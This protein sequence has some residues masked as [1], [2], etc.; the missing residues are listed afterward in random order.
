MV[1]E[2]KGLMEKLWQVTFTIL[3]VVFALWLSVRLLA[4]IWWVLMII[5]GLVAVVYIA[6]RWWQWRR[7]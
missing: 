4:Q 3:A 5:G 2:P 6:T 7:W 1:G